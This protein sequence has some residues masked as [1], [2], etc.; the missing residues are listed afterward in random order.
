MNYT[1]LDEAPKKIDA[2]KN[3]YPS[4]TGWD[5]NL[6]S[7]G[8]VGQENKQAFVV[9]VAVVVAAVFP[10]LASVDLK[11]ECVLGN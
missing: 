2:S 3:G 10:S 11:S 7:V 1:D 8:P 9:A 6:N 5:W 4:G